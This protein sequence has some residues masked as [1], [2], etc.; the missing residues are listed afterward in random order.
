MVMS[1]VDAVGLYAHFSWQPWT[2]TTENR[3]GKPNGGIS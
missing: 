2:N 3:L 1:H